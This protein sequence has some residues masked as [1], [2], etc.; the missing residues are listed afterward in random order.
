MAT[1]DSW[2]PT[3]KQRLLSHILQAHPRLLDVYPVGSFAERVPSKRVLS[4]LH[5]DEHP[6][7]SWHTNRPYRG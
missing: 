5:R 1:R 3:S 6:N 2:M 4:L 7:C